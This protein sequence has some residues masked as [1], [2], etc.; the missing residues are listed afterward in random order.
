MIKVFKYQ[1]GKIKIICNELSMVNDYKYDWKKHQVKIT[2]FPMR[3]NYQLGV[4]LIQNRGGRIC[5]G[6]LA[7]Q[8]QPNNEIDCVKIDVAFTQE[9][10]TRYYDSC[11]YDDN[12]VY[13]GLPKEYVESIIQSATLS[14]LE[15]KQYPQCRLIFE[16]AANCEVGSSPMIFRIISEII[17]NIIFENACEKIIDMDIKSFSEKFVNNINMRY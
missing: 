17:I 4:E 3:L 1:N 11:L 9:N 7:V 8:A 13:K 14:I 12:Y 10:S 15:K 16:Y 5:Y 6:M 2:T